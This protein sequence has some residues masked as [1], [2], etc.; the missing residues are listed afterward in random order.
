MNLFARMKNILTNHSDNQ[1]GLNMLNNNEV[2]I[3]KKIITTAE[4]A[5]AYT[6]GK[7]IDK[8]LG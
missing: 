1:K 8:V 5:I 2:K 3:E 7:V 4:F 6:F